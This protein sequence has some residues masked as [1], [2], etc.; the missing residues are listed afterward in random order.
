MESCENWCLTFVAADPRYMPQAPT[1]KAICV[2]F[3]S[4]LSAMTKLKVV[5]TEFPGS[6]PWKYWWQRNLLPFNRDVP[7]V[8]QIHTLSPW[9]GKLV[10]GSWI[11]TNSG[12]AK[13]LSQHYIQHWEWVAWGKRMFVLF[14]C[15]NPPAQSLQWGYSDLHLLHDWW[16]TEKPCQC[17]LV[18]SIPLI[19][20]VLSISPPTTITPLPDLC[21][22][23]QVLTCSM[24][25]A[26]WMHAN[27]ET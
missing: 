2:Y 4:Q 20:W 13:L 8:C 21:T 17:V 6:L 7:S 12:T 16:K 9:Q 19:F 25:C 10:T 5:L 14:S 3:W 23:W 22:V 15:V 18:L 1:C 27:G 11:L 24:Y 26:S